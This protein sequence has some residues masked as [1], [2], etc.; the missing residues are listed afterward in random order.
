MGLDL[1]FHNGIMKVMSINLINQTH[2]LETPKSAMRLRAHCL[3]LNDLREMAEMR[4]S[5]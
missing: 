4:V 5:Y 3:I 1:F 2:G